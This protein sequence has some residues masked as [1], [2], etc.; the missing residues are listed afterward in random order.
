[1]WHLCFCFC[2]SLL[3]CYNKSCV[4]GNF[5]PFSVFQRK[6]NRPLT[7]CCAVKDTSALTWLSVTGLNR[8]THTQLDHA[9]WKSVL[10]PQA[11]DLK[12]NSAEVICVWVSLSSEASGGIFMRQIVWGSKDCEKERVAF[13]WVSDGQIELLSCE[14]LHKCLIGSVMEQW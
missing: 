3:H 12:L 6:F 14:W 7:A 13:Y 5:E 9:Q 10:H 4:F 8:H 1:M 11:Y 2:K